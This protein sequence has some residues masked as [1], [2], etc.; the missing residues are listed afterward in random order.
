MKKT[1]L[2]GGAVTILALA[3]MG[4]E[5]T[6]KKRLITVERTGNGWHSTVYINPYQVAA[7]EQAQANMDGVNTR[8]YFGSPSRKDDQTVIFGVSNDYNDF[9][10]QME[11]ALQ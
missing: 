8:I 2:F 7:F 10:Q 11:E 5:G 9:R 4:F 3:I 1:L 6:E